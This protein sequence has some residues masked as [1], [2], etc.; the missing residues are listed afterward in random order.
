MLPL[1][2]RIQLEPET[3]DRRGSERHALGLP[4][5]GAILAVVENISETGLALRTE[6]ALALGDT[7][8]VEL[9]DDGAVAARVAWVDDGIVGGEFLVPLTRAA[10]SAARLRSPFEPIATG[11]DTPVVYVGTGLP[12]TP[13]YGLAIGVMCAFV[14]VGA[15]FVV[16]LLTAPNSV[17]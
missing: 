9:P 14:L 16:A 4:V 17:Y 3:I 6:A 10:V 8:E 11:P 15:M 5:A 13:R 12:D 1:A 7:F 2:T